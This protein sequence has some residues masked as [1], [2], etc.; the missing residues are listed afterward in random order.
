MKKI[1]FIAAI[2]ALGTTSC[3][4]DRTC[5][6]SGGGGTDDKIT[7]VKV[8][9]GQAKANCISTKYDDGNGGTVTITCKLD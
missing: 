7:L 6:C 2:A 1:L 9:K 5:T 4:K 3:S 8:T